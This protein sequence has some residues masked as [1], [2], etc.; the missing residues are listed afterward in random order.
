MGKFLFFFTSGQTWAWRGTRAFSCN[1]CKPIE[2]HW[3]L[4]ETR[5]WWHMHR[6]FRRAH[7]HHQP[8]TRH[9]ERQVSHGPRVKTSR[10]MV[11]R[12]YLRR[13]PQ[14]EK[15]EEENADTRRVRRG[16]AASLWFLQVLDIAG[17]QTTGTSAEQKMDVTSVCL[18]HHE[19]NSPSPWRSLEVRSEE[20]Q[21][22][23]LCMGK[24]VLNTVEHWTRLCPFYRSWPRT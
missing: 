11:L 10:W 21:R 24:T 23:K 15:E 12:A 4:K 14:W 20:K 13:D 16:T 22:T 2:P 9:G 3:N 17:D 6:D 1:V 5:V 7:H 19:S 18:E 8:Q